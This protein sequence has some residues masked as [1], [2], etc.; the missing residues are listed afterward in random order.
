[1]LN[2]MGR[3]GAVLGQFG[4]AQMKADYHLKY[5]GSRWVSLKKRHLNKDRVG[6]VSSHLSGLC[7]EWGRSFTVLFTNL[8]RVTY[9]ADTSQLLY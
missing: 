5:S 2:A 7:V 9:N 3:G 6:E 8:E 1:M 4:S